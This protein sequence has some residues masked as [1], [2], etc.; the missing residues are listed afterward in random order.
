MFEL[1]LLNLRRNG[2]MVGMGEWLALLD[3][4][5]KGL[6]GT[7]PELYRLGRA[8]LIHKESQFDAWDQAFQATFAGVE[9]PEPLSAAV[10]Q[11]LQQSIGLQRPRRA[12]G[13]GQRRAV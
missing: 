13:R 3:A 10:Q 2:V 1:L 8:I 12:A 11:W 4:I 7:L 6:A 5:G 9:L